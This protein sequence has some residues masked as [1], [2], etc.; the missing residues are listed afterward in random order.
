[1]AMRVRRRSRTHSSCEETDVRLKDHVVRVSVAGTAV[2]IGILLVTVRALSLNASSGHAGAHLAIGLPLLILLVVVLRAWPP[3]RPGV[4]ARL[5]RGS[6]V[7]GLALASLGLIAEA[8][9]AFGF[10]PDGDTVVNGLATL[11]DLSNFVWVVGMVAIGTSALLRSVDVLAQA[12]GLQST[13]ALTVAGVV[14]VLAVTAFAVGGMLL[15]Y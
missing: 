12:H 15:D 11:H 4:L 5:A 10:G 3:V 6:L 8:V 13:R 7:V 1:M 9:G 2:L 14:V